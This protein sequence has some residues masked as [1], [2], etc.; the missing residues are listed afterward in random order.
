[1]PAGDRPSGMPEG[2]APSAAPADGNQAGANGGGR[3]RMSKE[4]PLS[5]AF[6]ANTEWKKLYEQATTDL[7]AKLIED[8][9]LTETV[10]DW[11]Q[12]LTTGAA[13]LVATDT[14]TTEADK[15]RSY[16]D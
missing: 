6:L 2:A 9:T 4:N 11:S 10:D 3:G 13:D 5:T 15:I 7:Q 12:L 8:G 1:M 16:A 14:L